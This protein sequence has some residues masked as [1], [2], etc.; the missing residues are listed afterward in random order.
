MDEEIYLDSAELSQHRDF[1]LQEKY[2]IQRIKDN[3]DSVKNTV[4]DEII[5][6]R[7]LMR[8]FQQLSEK[9]DMAERFYTALYSALDEINVEADLTS[10]KIGLL[11]EDYIEEMSRKQIFN[12]DLL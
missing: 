5:V 11:L 12:T 4:S 7:D 3:F 1:V 9:L 8:Q 10:R 2:T 6:N